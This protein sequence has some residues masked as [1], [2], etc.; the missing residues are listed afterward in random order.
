MTESRYHQYLV[1][2]ALSGD[3]GNQEQVEVI[4]E[5]IGSEADFGEVYAIEVLDRWCRTGALADV[6]RTAKA[7]A[8]IRTTAPDGT[9]SRTTAAYSR[10]V[11][12]T[13]SG[14]VV[15]TQMSIFWDYTRAQLVEL[16]EDDRIQH[17]RTGLNL[18]QRLRVLA[19]MDAH[20]ECVTAG[21]AWTTAGHDLGEIDLSA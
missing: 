14:S 5:L 10:P 1:D 16:I 7:L 2:L 15:G 13:D 18:D 19:T 20:P 9:K 11:R 8:P 17:K 3:R 6:R 21:Q 12:D 4:A